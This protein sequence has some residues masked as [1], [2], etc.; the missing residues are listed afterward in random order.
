MGQVCKRCHEKLEWR[1]Q[2]KKYKPL[3]VMGRWC[4]NAMLLSLPCVLAVSTGVLP[5]VFGRTLD[6]RPR[7]TNC[8]PSHGIVSLQ[9]HVP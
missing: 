7:L 5:A 4:V 2:F 6:E 3:T 8:I 9:R 1:K